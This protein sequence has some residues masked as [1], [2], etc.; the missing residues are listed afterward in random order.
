MRRAIKTIFIVLGILVAL[1]ALMFI[2][3]ICPPSGPWPMPPWCEDGTVGTLKNDFGCWPPSC[4]FIP[5]EKGRQLCEDWKTGKQVTWPSDC[6]AMPFEGCKKLCEYERSV[7]SVAKIDL[8]NAIVIPTNIE[9]ITYPDFYMQTKSVDTTINNPY[10]IIEATETAYPATYLGDYSL[11]QIKGAPLLPEIKRIVGLKDVWVDDPNLNG[12]YYGGPKK[13]IMFE[14]YEKTL[15]RVKMLGGEII[16]ISNYVSFSNFQTA[17]I[18]NNMPAIKDEML[19]K[20]VRTAKSERLDVILYLNLAPGK[21][22]VGEIPS[23]EWLATLID[24]YEPFLLNQAKIAEETGIKGIMLNHF[25]Y[26]PGIKGHEA[27]Y[28]RKMLELIKK[29]RSVYSGQ[30]ILMIEPLLDA[31]YTKISEVLSGVDAYIYTPQT[32]VLMYSKDKTVSV[33]NLKLL[34][35]ENLK[36]VGDAVGKY[37]KSVYL[38]ILIQSERDFLV[39]GW[40]EDM[41]CT[42]RG[43]DPCYQ[44]KLKPDFSLQ[45]IAYEALMEAIRE[46]HGKF[47]NVAGTD[48]YGYWFTDV[49]LSRN[50][51]PQI[52]QSTRNKPAE[53]ILKEWFKK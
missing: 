51:Q 41:F 25:D 12:C 48:T 2:F 45:A 35:L 27:T 13:D 18:E 30:L 20:I 26:Q 33:E 29:V 6:A 23:D 8:T 3:K 50:S 11:P 24:N 19:R 14:S 16:S 43:S 37:N 40:N 17:G 15:P 7:K 1:L 31:D 52:A 49:L 38:R 5:D 47:L 28:Q 34:Y 44:A 4:S 21:E 9:K 42:Q 32:A 46:T 10:C 53:S 36:R 22:K 39:N